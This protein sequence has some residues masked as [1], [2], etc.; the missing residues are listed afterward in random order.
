MITLSE[1]I[2]KSGLH[3]SRIQNVYIFGSQVYSTA[4]EISDYDILIIAKTP[5][6]EKEL[7]VDNCNIHILTLD[8]FLEG[9][10]QHHIGRLE[11]LMSP[12][13][14]RLK[15]EINIPIIIK[16]SGLRHSISHTVSNS[17]IKS[18]K[19]LEQGDYYLGIKSLFHSLRIAMFGLQII[20]HGKIVDFKCANYIWEELKSKTWNWEELNETFRPLRNKIM[21]DFRSVTNKL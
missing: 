9:L 7:V 10:K 15:E 21:T 8:R 11:C 12:Q 19:K 3:P 14:W 4:S 1:I 20:N 5:Y 17:W 6:E 16:E 13:K 2:E 18:K